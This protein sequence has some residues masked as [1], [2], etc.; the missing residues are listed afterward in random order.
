MDWENVSHNWL[1]FDKLRVHNLNVILYESPFPY[2]INGHFQKLEFTSK[3]S[4]FRK[5]ENEVCAG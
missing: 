1:C 5:L 4:F 3:L 2:Q